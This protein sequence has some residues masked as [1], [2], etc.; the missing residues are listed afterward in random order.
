M[1]V[2][3][4]TGRAAGL[5]AALL[6]A[7]AIPAA[8][9]QPCPP[10]ATPQVEL[11]VDEPEVTHDYGQPFAVLHQRTGT[12]PPDPRRGPL[13]LGLTI[14]GLSFSSALDFTAMTGIEGACLRP[15]RVR[16]M[17]RQSPHHV[18]I[19]SEVPRGGCLFQEVLAHEMRHVAVNR[20][21]LAKWAPRVR[22]A[23]AAWAKDAIARGDDAE[24]VAKVLRDRLGAAVAPVLNRLKADRQ[25]AQAA[26][27]TPAEYRRIAASCFADHVRIRSGLLARTPVRRQR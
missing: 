6:L 1:A 16:L 19:A 13:H 10:P 7:V 24:A 14:A 12:R 21:T 9:A 3:R 2:A 17:L 27:D 11:V 26:I 4:L 23:A 8:R 15:R 18:M 5:V 25:R 20:Q 22:E